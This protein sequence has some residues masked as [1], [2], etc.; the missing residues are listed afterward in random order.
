[1]GI[2][3]TMDSGGQMKE[4]S[5][6]VTM[7]GTIVTTAAS[8]ITNKMTDVED[9]NH[10]IIDPARIGTIRDSIEDNGPTEE[11]I[12]VIGHHQNKR[13]IIAV[14]TDSGVTTTTS[15]IVKVVADIREHLQDKHL[16]TPVIMIVL[17]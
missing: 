4:T 17:L 13:M 8:I 5:H 10:S 9:I 1:M 12:E 2:I 6:S 11:L 3:I 15:V 7:T 14:I 16:R